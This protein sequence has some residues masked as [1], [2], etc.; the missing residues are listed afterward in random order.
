VENP[1]FPHLVEN[2]GN[3]VLD[4]CCQKRNVNTGG[5]SHGVTIMA[6]NNGL[7][8]VRVPEKFIDQLEDLYPDTAM[9]NNVIRAVLKRIIEKKIIITSYEIDLVIR[10]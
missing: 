4:S 5:Q 2:K 9:R 6:I 7:L 8:A 1:N 10:S 3:I